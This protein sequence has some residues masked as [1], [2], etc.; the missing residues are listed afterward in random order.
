[1]LAACQIDALID[2]P[3]AAGHVCQLGVESS[4]S[5]ADAT[6]QEIVVGDNLKW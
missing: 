4:H 3:I 6:V 5:R 1:M 2:C